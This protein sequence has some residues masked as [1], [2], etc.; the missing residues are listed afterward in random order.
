MSKLSLRFRVFLFFALLAVGGAGIV[1]LSLWLGYGRALATTSD[2]GFF[3]AGV[4]AVFGIVALCTGIWLL[5]DENIAKPVE[6]LAAEMRIRAHAG[7]DKQVDTH[8]ARYLGDLAHAAQ[9]VSAKLG[10]TALQ[11]AQRVADETAQLAA[12]KARLTALLTEIPV[13]TIMVS[14]KGQIVLYD[15]QAAEVLSQIHVPRLNAAITDYFL[16]SGVE[17]AVRELHRTGREVALTLRSVDEAQSYD[18]RMKPLDG[19]GYLLIIEGAHASIAPE[20]ERPLV[21]DFS[22]L[23]AH[24]PEAIEE[25]PL[26]ALTYVVFDTETTGLLP[27]KDEVVQIG[28][29]RVV[30]GRIVPGERID[31]LVDPGAPIP[32]SSTK[33]HRVTD[34]MVR[35]KPDIFEAGRRFHHFARNA[36][37]VAHNAP[38]DMAFLRRHQAR[39]GVEWS[40]PILDTVLLSAVL[41]GTTE[42]HTLDALCERLGVTIPPELRHTALGD[43]QATAE[44]LVR[45]LPMLEARGMTTFGEVVE[46]TRQH[47]RLLEDLN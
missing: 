18:G 46:Q 28:A 21:F 7:I 34:A 31:Q 11:S 23:T 13:A 10:E 47:G 40:N 15:G 2:N 24:A 4:L 3:F 1:A 17:A 19:G 14:P 22:L 32:P 41:F 37:I 9:A 12:D 16:A 29:V 5:F 43:A 8:G 44:V 45:M 39:M 30:G 42:T 27:H 38:F 25:T 26:R 36:V 6:S 35:G 33:V 20:A